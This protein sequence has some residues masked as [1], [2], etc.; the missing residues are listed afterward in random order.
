MLGHGA[1]Y[2]Q[3]AADA[4]IVQ[5]SIEQRGEEEREAT[6]FYKQPS[7]ERETSKRRESEGGGWFAP[8][9]ERDPLVGVDSGQDIGHLQNTTTAASEKR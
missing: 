4:L 2:M 3:L 1:L 8:L 5:G 9:L 7:E 6:R